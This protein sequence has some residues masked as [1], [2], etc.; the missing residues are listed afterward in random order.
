MSNPSSRGKPLAVPPSEETI[1]RS[2]RSFMSITRRQAT[3]RLSMPSVLP[4]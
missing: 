2:A 1:E 3:R 4:Q